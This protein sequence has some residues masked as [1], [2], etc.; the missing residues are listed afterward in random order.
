MNRA[1]ALGGVLVVVAAVVAALLYTG[2][3]SGTGPT[4]SPAPT[5]SV[6]PSPVHTPSP[7]PTPTPRVSPTPI[8]TSIVA[9]AVVIPNQSSDLAIPVSGIVAGVYVEENQDVTA[10]ELLVKL[11]Q[12]TYL[13]QI[14]VAQSDVTRADAAVT[15]AQ[16]ALNQL[17]PDAT[18]DQVSAAQADLGLAQA[19]LRLAN[20]NYNAAQVA[21]KQ[22][23]VRAPFAGTVASVNV[24]V[25]EQATAG[26]T[27]VTIGDLSS[28][29]I[30]TTDLSEL[31]VVRVAVGDRATITI[32]ALPGV[33]LTGSVSRIQVRGTNADGGVVFAVAIRPDQAPPQLRWGMT[34]TVHIKPNG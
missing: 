33:A 24:A 17:P 5:P 10:D 4:P 25:G 32:G 27:V 28:W 1:M 30:E 31:E 15:R 20:S 19:E 21:L 29:L 8:D 11:D 2:V 23:E 3:L 7:T 13:A 34:A 9:A 16:L 12:S 18:P 26:E 22:T 14:N 6:S